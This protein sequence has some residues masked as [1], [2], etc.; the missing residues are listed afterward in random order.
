MIS[1]SEKKIGKESVFIVT[2]FAGDDNPT[3]IISEKIIRV[4]TFTSQ[5]KGTERYLIYDSDM[6]VI[7]DTYRFLNHNYKRRANNTVNKS[8]YALKFLYV[9]LEIFDKTAQ[10]LDQDDLVKLT[11][12]LTGVTSKGQN[13]QLDLLTKRGK[14]T[15]NSFFSIYR[16]YFRFLRIADSPIFNENSYAKYVP[17]K[18]KTQVQQA[19][20]NFK[21]PPKYISNSDFENIIH[22]I[23]KNSV[24]REIALRNE[25]LVRVMF[26]GG[27]RLGEALG[28]T[29]E[30]YILKEIDGK[31]ICFVYIRNR[32]SNLPYQ[33]AKTCMNVW[34]KKNYTSF[35]YQKEGI[36]YQLTYLSS[37]TYDLLMD[38]IDLSQARADK[39]CSVAY[40]SKAKADAV[41]T[42]KE[43]NQGN[44]YVFIN[45]K[46]TPLSSSSWNK[47]L[48]NIFESVGLPVDYGVKRYNLSHRFRHGFVMNLL[49]EQ[50][51]SAEQV[52]ERTRHKGITSLAA[53][54]TPTTEDTV[55]LKIKI[56][57]KINE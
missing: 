54:Y 24:N 47:I 15:V 52:I 18:P 19:N 12:F 35:E 31:S 25:C 5:Y 51:L 30:D 48:R 41:A 11:Y 40:E 22:Y 56:E 7:S 27:L 21:Q 26:E 9:F 39:T 20:K 49:H 34:D 17:N 10:Q 8:M 33:N 23:R 2:T 16:D 55:R 44:Y 37:D 53:Y 46:C 29:I 3:N 45:S 13:I 1:I 42:C 36:G 38:Y 6:N 43:S 28:S 32:V 14:V 50:K 4:R 57:D